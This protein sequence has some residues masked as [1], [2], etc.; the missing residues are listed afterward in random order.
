MSSTLDMLIQENALLTQLIHV[1]QE[2][3]KLRMDALE[4]RIKQMEAKAQATEPAPVFVPEEKANEP[5]ES[6]V[7]AK[8]PDVEP[9]EIPGVV[10][11]K[12]SGCWC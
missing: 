12:R 1:Q 8:K 7:E 4:E 6:P 9:K 11:V 5:T 10:E 2:N 3:T